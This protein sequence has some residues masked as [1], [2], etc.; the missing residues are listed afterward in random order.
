MEA[1]KLGFEKI[2]IS[3]YNLKGLDIKNYKIEVI[4]VSKM[5]DVFAKLFG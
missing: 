4:A 2:Y 5:E 3:S 1:Q